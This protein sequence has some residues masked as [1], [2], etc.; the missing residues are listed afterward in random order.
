MRENTQL[1]PQ[2]LIVQF[3]RILNL[4][5]PAASGAGAARLRLKNIARNYRDGAEQ[6]AGHAL[7]LSSF[8]LG[9]LNRKSRGRPAAYLTEIAIL[10]TLLRWFP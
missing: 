6:A 3:T 5:V 1:C 9:I 7:K 4:S 10:G 2:A 8:R